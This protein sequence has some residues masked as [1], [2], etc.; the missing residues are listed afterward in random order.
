M[1]TKQNIDF[2]LVSDVTLRNGITNVTRSGKLWPMSQKSKCGFCVRI[3]EHI[4]LFQM[5]PHLLIL[6]NYSQRYSSLHISIR[7][8]NCTSDTI[9][10]DWSFFYFLTVLPKHVFH[11][12]TWPGKGFAGLDQFFTLITNIEKLKSLIELFSRKIDFIDCSRD[13]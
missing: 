9:Q 4:F 3:K 2:L 13:R 1:L 12:K 10:G 5:I 7:E 11:T 6:T 8:T